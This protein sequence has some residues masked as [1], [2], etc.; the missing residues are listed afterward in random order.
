MGAEPIARPL[1]PDAGAVEHRSAL[2]DL[3][4]NTIPPSDLRANAVSL[5]FVSG[6]AVRDAD[7]RGYAWP[8]EVM[9]RLR[10]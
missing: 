3:E 10:Q 4:G 5:D 2:L 8:G 9:A 1:L 7:D 6:L